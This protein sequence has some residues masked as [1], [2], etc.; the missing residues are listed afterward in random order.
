M[1]DFFLNSIEFGVCAVPKDS[2]V[3]RNTSHRR[4]SCWDS[5]FVY[6]PEVDQICSCAM[7]QRLETARCL[8]AETR[9]TERKLF[10]SHAC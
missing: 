7:S 3:T 1:T 4:R 8:Q 5:D 6:A 2:V 9:E 10:A